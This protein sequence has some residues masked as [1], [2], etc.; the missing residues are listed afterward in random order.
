[1]KITTLLGLGL[2]LAGNT[3]HAQYHPYETFKFDILK[4]RGDFVRGANGSPAKDYWQNQ[5]D[6]KVNASFDTTNALLKGSVEINY[7]NNSPDFLNELWFQM[8]QN[9]TKKNSIGNLYANPDVAADDKDGYHIH[10]LEMYIDG[11]WQKMDFDVK[12]TRMVVPLLTSALKPGETAK[13]RIDYDYT[14]QEHGGGD[15]SGITNTANGKIYE[16]SYWYP[17]LCVYDDYYGWNTLP[18]VGGGEMYLDYGNIDYAITVPANGV[19]AGSGDLVNANEILNNNALA[20]LDKAK[21]SDMRVF[22]R[23]AKSLHKG[24]TK[25]TKGNVTW[26]FKMQNTRDV[27]WAY[28]NAYIWDAAKIN[29]PDGE[30]GLAQSVY[31]IESTEGESDWTHSTEYLK[32]SVESFS[33]RWFKFPYHTA[34]SVAG[35]T[36]GM[37]YPALAFND[38][39]VPPYVMFLLASHEIGHTWFPMIVGSDERRYPFMDEGFNTFIDIYAHVD[40]DK[41][42]FAPKRDGEYAP[43]KGNPA[44]E[45]VSVIEANKNGA[46]LM[47]PPDAQDYKSVHPLAYFKSA[48]GLTLLRD[49]IMGP[50][51]FDFAFRNYIKDWSFKH[52]RPDDFFRS[53]EN[54]AGMDLC[55]F[56]NGWY[57]HNW[58]F[59]Q[60]I[61]SVNYES[62]KSKGAFITVKNNDKMVFPIIVKVTETNGKVHSFRVPV[63]VWQRGDTAKFKVNSTGTIKSVEL[64]PEHQL[65]DTNRANNVWNG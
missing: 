48:F 44:D 35:G 43:G 56:W 27:A 51:T 1:M 32:A 40:Y 31:P 37:E 62:D 45:I 18:F 58:Q 3:A 15:R 36:G 24:V 23:D 13:L 14:L 47:T 42:K 29:L 10:S 9:T 54:G 19:I 11:H 30:T 4:Y 26:H 53:M 2:L 64:D 33:N 60:A 16:I 6:Y 46:T 8:D 52:P 28:S 63:E 22:I 59:D 39:K 12:D 61:E 49:V 20:Q 57:Y 7:V 65:P 34:S 21:K 17:R 38:Y 50:K 41:G 55:W 5:A 25:A